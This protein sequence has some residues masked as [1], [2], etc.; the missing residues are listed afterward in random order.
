MNL[1]ALWLD[2]IR[3]LL[4]LMSSEANLGLGLAIA[5]ATLLLRAAFLPISWSSGYRGCV[6]QKKMIRLQPELQKLKER[7]SGKPDLYMQH[8]TKLYQQHGLTLVDGK[9]LFAM[10]IQM[11]LFLGMYQVLRTVGEGVRFL[12]IP[13]LLKP[14]TVL[15]LL[16]AL[17]TA[18]MISANPDIPEQMR[19]LMIIVP[20]FIA[21]VA[22]LK[23]CSALAIYW[24][25]S[26][27]FSA[28]QTAAI[29]FVVGQRIRAGRLQI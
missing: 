7:F 14:D 28:L 3:G 21:F 2:A 19:M 25:A 23:F 13:N 9:S 5:A 22:A 16:A 20:S 8:M 1:W 15:A 12:W 17:T 24:T 18:L 26:N 4:D 27:C 29:H 11:P 10:L 6:R